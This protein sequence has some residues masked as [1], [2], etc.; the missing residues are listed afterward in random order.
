MPE[1]KKLGD[2]VTLI[3]NTK[4]VRNA[5]DDAVSTALNLIGMQD[6]KES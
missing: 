2:N 4:E 5:L 3:D 6:E 1:V